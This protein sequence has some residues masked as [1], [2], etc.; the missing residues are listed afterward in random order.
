MYGCLYIGQSLCI[1]VLYM[2]KKLK[3]VHLK[4]WNCFP[5]LAKVPCSRFIKRR[6]ISFGVLSSLSSV[7][8]CHSLAMFNNSVH[9]N[10][11]VHIHLHSLMRLFHLGYCLHNWDVTQ[12]DTTNRTA[13]YRHLYPLNYFVSRQNIKI[14]TILKTSTDMPRPKLST[15]HFRV[16]IQM[17]QKSAMLRT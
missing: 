12:V 16:W 5:F 4:K 8:L 17:N 6:V 14:N 11:I 10:I 3:Y 13:T 2:G 1:W 9:S 15:I 7:L